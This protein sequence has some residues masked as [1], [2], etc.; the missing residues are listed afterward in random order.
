MSKIPPGCSVRGVRGVSSAALPCSGWRSG[1]IVEASRQVRQP[2]ASGRR[3]RAVDRARPL[4]RFRSDIPARDTDMRGWPRGFVR[5]AARMAGGLTASTAD[6][7]APPRISRAGEGTARGT[8]AADRCVSTGRIRRPGS[9]PHA[10]GVSGQCDQRA[11]AGAF[12][13]ASTGIRD[14][15]GGC[16]PPRR[17]APGGA[18]ASAKHSHHYDSHLTDRPPRPH[19]APCAIFPT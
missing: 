18:T 10:A 9:K 12:R 1:A 7:A 3:S 11:D 2:P 6:T 14:A 8:G 4:C 13:G 17:R 16:Q 5:G 19:S 15:A